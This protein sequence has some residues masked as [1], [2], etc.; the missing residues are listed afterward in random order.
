ME[1]EWD[2]RKNQANR[3][4]HGISFEEAKYVFDGPTV[5]W[6]DNRWDYG[7]VREITIGV[8]RDVAVIVVVHTDRSGRIRLISARAANRDE[9]EIYNAHF[10]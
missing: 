2:E 9:R 10:R 7:E 8:I 3:A 4:K 6:I 5:S 1:F